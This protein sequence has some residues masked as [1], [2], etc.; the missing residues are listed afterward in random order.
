VADHADELRL[1]IHSMNSHYKDGE[2]SVSAEDFPRSIA[3]CL[4]TPKSKIGRARSCRL[5]SLWHA[6]RWIS[7]LI[8]AHRFFELGSIS[9]TLFDYFQMREPG[10]PSVSERGRREAGASVRGFVPAL[11][12]R[13]TKKDFA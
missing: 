1:V 12:L 5:A 8:T 11:P 6:V 3:P 10:E 7:Q 13:L 2:S 4:Q 9:R